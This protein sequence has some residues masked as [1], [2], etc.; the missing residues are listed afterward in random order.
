MSSVN[1]FAAAAARIGDTPQPF[2]EI[3]WQRIPKAEAVRQ[4]VG[5]WHLRQIK[6]AGPDRPPVLIP[7]SCT[8]I[9]V[10]P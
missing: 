5:V 8:A 2:R 1:G 3:L 4:L 7:F 10:P 9:G 6:Q